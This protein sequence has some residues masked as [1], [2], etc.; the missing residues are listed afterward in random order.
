MKNI[1]LVVPT[2]CLGGQERICV[3]TASLL[4][5]HYNVKLV[6][7]D[8]EKAVFEPDVETL[9]INVPAREGRINKIKGVLKRAFKLR[10]IRKK[11]KPAAVYSFGSSAN[12]VNVL[13]GGGGKT[14]IGVRGYNTIR[15]R[16][17]ADVYSFKKADKVICCAQELC[18]YLISTNTAKPEKIKCLYNP[19]D[20]K[21]IT[22]MAE[23]N[24]DDYEFSKHVIVSHGRLEKVKNWPR[25]IRAFSIVKKKC[26]DAQLL[27]IGE[28][29]ERENLNSLIR[30]FRL[31]DSVTLIGYKKNP[32]KYLKES[33]LYVLSSYAEGFP[34]SL[35]EGM[36]FLP[37]VSVDCKTGPREIL[38]EK[39]V[40]KTAKNIDREDY[41]LLVSPSNNKSS[42]NIITE[43]DETL[44][45]AIMYYI[46]DEH[47]AE[48]YKKRSHIRAEMFSCEEYTAKLIEIIEK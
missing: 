36:L 23:E 11:I 24:V 4:K 10:N 33:N 1:I 16:T 6:V 13:S 21:T 18:D 3:K 42:G 12:I 7:F 9:N 14:I 29:E 37:A 35:V 32:F 22:R 43:D 38:S 27:I 34:N 20:V 39:S 8:T 17:M 46:N 41:G 45:E 30:S 25:L 28:G 44:A 15:K 19:V 31:E 26:D 48:V 5:I 47:M 40:I 2:L